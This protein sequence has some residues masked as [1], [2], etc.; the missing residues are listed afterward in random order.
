L[1]LNRKEEEKL[2]PVKQHLYKEQYQMNS[3]NNKQRNLSHVRKKS[4][5][6]KNEIGRKGTV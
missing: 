6:R 5:S 2:H 1:N 4:N 3:E